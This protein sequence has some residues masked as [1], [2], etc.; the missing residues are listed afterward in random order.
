MARLSRLA[1]LALL[2]LLAAPPLQTH[3]N[4]FTY[5]IVV[6]NPTSYDAW[7]TI[8]SLGKVRIEKAGRVA[9]HSKV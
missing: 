3:A 6:S 1:A 2:T 7:I 8:Y 5:N 9:A 4:P